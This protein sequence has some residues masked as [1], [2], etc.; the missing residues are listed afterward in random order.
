[1]ANPYFNA[2][3][4][5][6]NNPDLF[7]AGVT[8]ATAWDHYV[9]YGA[10]EAYTAGGM[11]RAPNAWFDA[12]FYLLNNQDLIANGVT[13]ETAFDHFTSFGMQELRSPNQQI[14]NDPITSASLLAYV[15]A[16]SD[17]ATALNVTIPAT[18]LTSAQQNAAVAQ[19]YGYGFSESRPS[20][21]TDFNPNPTPVGSTFTLTTGSDYA[22]VSG[23]Y[24]NGSTT[25]S[26]FKF[27]S[28]NETVNGT[29]LTL[30]PAAGTIVL[31]S[32]LD[33]TT[34]DSDILNITLG[35][36]AAMGATT[37]SNIENINVSVGA[38][39]SAL[40][41]VVNL[42]ATTGA[43]TLTISGASAQPITFAGGNLAGTG[44]TTVD[45]SGMTS[46]VNGLVASFATSTSTAA[47]TITGSAAGDTFTGVG[48]NDTIDGGA[49]NDNIAGG[50]GSD[51]LLGGAGNDTISGGANNDTIDGG[52]GNDTL[53]GDAGNDVVNGGAGND[54]I[55]TGGG[56]DTITGGA[57][58][59]TITLTA[60]A[61]NSET[62]VFESTAAGN[63][64]DTLNIFTAGA[65]NAGGDVLDFTAF[66]GA[67]GTYAGAKVTAAAAGPAG[68]GYTTAVGENVVVLQNVLAWGNDLDATELQAGALR[69]GANTSGVIVYEGLADAVA[70]Y[71]TTDANSAY[72]S[73]ALVGTLAGAGGAGVL[74]YV[75]ANFA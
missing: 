21:P 18:E 56:A 32:L 27:T 29:N 9:S 30:Q 48:G 68:T 1:M 10:Q 7:A 52:A 13:P 26:D 31:D 35:A 12:Q 61:G 24:R 20:A 70:Y 46:A 22:D 2:T 33:G 69:F 19:Y 38:T 16:N 54:T 74:T 71:V 17:V 3:Y 60:G 45:A 43:K 36:G 64:T 37:I 28:G 25:P 65:V 42:T 58:N 62:V 63:G 67:E 14:A 8:V 15:N 59:D 4:Y 73:V 57:G 6:A 49:G 44:I 72:A 53:N 75:D 41:A 39:T 11:T 34:T 23:S 50:A 5:L 51:S 47:L 55:A 66:L 40:A